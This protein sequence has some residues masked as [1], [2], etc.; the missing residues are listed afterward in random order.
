MFAWQLF[1]TMHAI[2]A[3][4]EARNCMLG[5]LHVY[6]SRIIAQPAC[7]HFNSE[8]NGIKGRPMSESVRERGVRRARARSAANCAA[9]NMRRLMVISCGR[10]PSTISAATCRRHHPLQSMSRQRSQNIYLPERTAKAA[11]SRQVDDIE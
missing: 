1:D 2:Q 9:R 8:G 3:N 6:T 4:F 7:K 10:S 11:S 5:T